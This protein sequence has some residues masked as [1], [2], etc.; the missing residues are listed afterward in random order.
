MPPHRP[1]L[2][3]SRNTPPHRPSL[4]ASRNMP[5]HRPSLQVSR[6]MPP[7]RPSLQVSRNMPPHRPSLQASRNTPPHRPSLQVSRNTPPERASRQAAHSM[8]SLPLRGTRA[9]QGRCSPRPV[10]D[11]EPRPLRPRFRYTDRDGSCIRRSDR[12]RRCTV[13]CRGYA[14]AKTRPPL[15]WERSAHRGTLRPVSGIAGNRLPPARSC[16]VR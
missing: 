2:Q 14:C 15:R 10:R 5:P 3:A 9:Q 8:R 16:A 4:Q 6:N 7:H 12:N 13:A 11:D 1:S